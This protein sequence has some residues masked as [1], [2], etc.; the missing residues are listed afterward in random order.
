L[1]S[2]VGYQT[3]E[4]RAKAEKSE[5]QK[6]ELQVAV[7]ELNSKIGHH[8][9]ELKVKVDKGDDAIGGVERRLDAVLQEQA[10]GIGGVEKRLDQ[11]L[12]EHAAGVGGVEKRLDEALQEHAAGIGRLERQ[13]EVKAEELDAQR[14][15]LEA[16]LEELQS[17]FGVH[18]SELQ[19][20]AAKGD[21]AI[22]V[23]ERRFQEALKEHAAAIAR[24]EQQLQLKVEESDKKHQSLQE[25]MAE[26]TMAAGVMNKSVESKLLEMGEAPQVVSRECAH[27]L[28]AVAYSL[29][30]VIGEVELTGSISEAREKR[31]KLHQHL[32]D[33]LGAV[34]PTTPGQ[35]GM[36]CVPPMLEA[37]EAQ[38]AITNGEVHVNPNLRPL[39]L[40]PSRPRSGRNS[41][42]HHV[43]MDDLVKNVEAKS[44]EMRASM[45]N[46]TSTPRS[47][48]KMLHG[49]REVRSMRLMD[50]STFD[51]SDSRPSTSAR[52]F[53]GGM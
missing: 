27:R 13:L 16:T 22:P 30:E 36:S 37:N 26:L 5:I 31:L 52:Y 8:T 50:Y 1:Q 32:C 48:K 44:V 10:A 19:A 15:E 21:E 23:V 6:H 18:A 42:S 41:R 9:D 17:R 45:R 40:P 24:L 51:D 29:L 43:D 47:N 35:H 39:A 12:Q 49:L 11:A 33:R 53:D 34:R 20:I 28:H 46:S 38:G 3:D 2:R 4:M 7:T 14:L 25:A